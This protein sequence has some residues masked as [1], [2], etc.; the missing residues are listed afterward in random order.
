MTT[1]PLVRLKPA[2]AGSTG[3]PARGARRTLAQ[4]AMPLAVPTLRRVKRVLVTGMSGTGKSNVVR[5]LVARGY[6][7]VDTDDRWV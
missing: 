7:A 3:D 5:E 6:R 4:R 1:L 2:G